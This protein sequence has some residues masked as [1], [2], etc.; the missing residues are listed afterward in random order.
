M[1][2]KQKQVKLK[3]LRDVNRILKKVQEKE[4]KVLFTKI[5]EKDQLCVIGI[6]DA[7]YHHDDKSMAREL[8]IIGNQKTG[9]AA[10]LYWRLGVIRKVCISPKAAEIRSLLRL[11]D[12]G[13]HMAKQLGQLLNG[14][15]KT[16]LFTE[17]SPLLE[18]I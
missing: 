4:S 7:S 6:S 14:N 3:D 11:M 15:I 9:K 10:P 13:V 2:K 5:G 18:S 17:L 16:R 8:I 1:A 12:D